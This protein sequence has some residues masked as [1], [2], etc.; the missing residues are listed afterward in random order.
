VAVLVELSK[1]L[2]RPLQVLVFATVALACVDVQGGAVEFYWTIRTTDGG[3]CTCQ[4]AGI[5]AI[6]LVGTRCDTVTPEG[7]CLG[8]AG[9]T[10]DAG[11][12]PTAPEFGVWNCEAS[13]GTTLFNI[14]EGRWSFRIQVTTPN[15]LDADAV[16]PPPIV[17]DVVSGEVAMLDALQ[18]TSTECNT[19]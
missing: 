18:I 12:A 1:C 3:S 15:G 4:N 13:R 2:R 8:P 19:P 14:D 7:V 5:S 10:A 6:H 11:P 17:R 9:T 16:L